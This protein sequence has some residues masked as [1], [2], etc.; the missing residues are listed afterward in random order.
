MLYFFI[1]LAFAPLIVLP[2]LGLI[3]KDEMIGE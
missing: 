1:V 3:I 2:I